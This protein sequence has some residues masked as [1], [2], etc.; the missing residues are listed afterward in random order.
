MTTFAEARDEVLAVLADAWDG[1]GFTLAWDDLPFDK[2]SAAPWARATLRHTVSAQATLS[3]E[4]GNRRFRRVG[5][6]F[7]QIFTPCGEGLSRGYSLAK[8]VTDAYEGERTAGVW[9]RN[10]TVKEIG[11]SDDWFQTN[12]TVEF[13]YDEVK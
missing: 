8:V 10:V 4:T 11:P 7:V 5:M 13:E 3:G 2:P 12:V 9:F 6:L 1:T